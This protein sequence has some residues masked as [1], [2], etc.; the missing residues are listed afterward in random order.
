[1]KNQV[2][3]D[4]LS[5]CKNCPPKLTVLNCSHGNMEIYCNRD[6]GRSSPKHLL[7]NHI[8]QIY[9]FINISKCDWLR[10]SKVRLRHFQELQPW[11]SISCSE[12]S[13][14]IFINHAWVKQGFLT[15]KDVPENRPMN[16]SSLY[17][18]LPATISE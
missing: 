2:K 13:G 5:I 16:S 14:P 12:G 6:L 3:N 9:K 4:A 11:K 1:M 18:L 10:K 8:A 15:E 17:C 7:A